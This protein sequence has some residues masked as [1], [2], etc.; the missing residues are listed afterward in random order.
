[1]NNDWREQA[2]LCA[3]K[4]RNG[5]GKSLQGIIEAGQGLIEAK[6][7]V[8]YG[9][10][11]NWLGAE[12]NMS[13]STARR[14]MKVSTLL[15]DEIVQADVSAIYEIAGK[16]DELQRICLWIARN[17]YLSNAIATAVTSVVENALD[18][19]G[20]L[21]GLSEDVIAL[22]TTH[23]IKPE[24]IPALTQLRV[25]YPNEFESIKESGALWVDEESIPLPEANA[26][27]FARLQS[28]LRS[29][30]FLEGMTLNHTSE[31][32]F[33][34]SGANL[35]DLPNDCI[36]GLWV[37]EGNFQELLN[38]LADRQG[39][40]IVLMAAIGDPL[41]HSGSVMIPVSKLNGTPPQWVYEIGSKIT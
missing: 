24:I 26:R 15:E 21:E 35:T 28:N 11:E 8:P 33:V 38:G 19:E 30:A 18:R 29:Q 40:P 13:E 4:V 7:I 12:F 14:Y 17:S 2:A 31:G 1:M 6:E 32:Y 23:D 16:P 27:D 20:L 36:V 39:R 34:V 37:T 22:V 3:V 25:Q 10:W 41:I 5:I 9:E